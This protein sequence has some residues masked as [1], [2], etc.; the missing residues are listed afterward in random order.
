MFFIFLL[1]SSDT[2]TDVASWLPRECVEGEGVWPPA[3]RA[4]KVEIE[5][6]DIDLGRKKRGLLVVHVTRSSGNV[7]SLCEY[8]SGTDSRRSVEGPLED[9]LVGGSGGG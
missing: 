1:D 6:V 7:G 3:E 2:P 4:M 8:I 5:S 9:G